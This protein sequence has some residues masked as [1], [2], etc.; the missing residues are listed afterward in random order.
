MVDGAQRRLFSA[1][2]SDSRFRDAATLPSRAGM[3][4]RWPRA[5]AATLPELYHGAPDQRV[6]L[7]PSWC[8]RT[9]GIARAQQLAAITLRD[10]GRQQRLAEAAFNQLHY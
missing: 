6:P 5:A 10:T 7:R 9:P 3:N 8:Y 1:L 2:A 4:A